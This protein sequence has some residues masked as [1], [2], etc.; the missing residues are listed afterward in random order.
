M[1]TKTYNYGLENPPIW[2]CVRFRDCLLTPEH[3]NRLLEIRELR[4]QKDP[5]GKTAL[6]RYDLRTLQKE[7]KQI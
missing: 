3:L 6:N 1:E 4:E 5:T 7:A 2:E